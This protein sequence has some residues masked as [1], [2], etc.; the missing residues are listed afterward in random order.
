MPSLIP[1]IQAEKRNLHDSSPQKSP[2]TPALLRQYHGTKTVFYTSNKTNCFDK[3]PHLDD[4]SPEAEKKS[5]PLKEKPKPG[6]FTFPS[7]F[8]YEQFLDWLPFQWEGLS[9]RLRQ[10][11]LIISNTRDFE[12]QSHRAS[13]N[14]PISLSLS[15]FLFLSLSFVSITIRHE[16]KSSGL[17]R[18]KR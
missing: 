15:L 10:K 8:V 9:L 5:T 18:A 12:W 3:R 11:K 16:S 17:Q 6:A 4:Y 14:V 1:A 2:T 7:F 13:S